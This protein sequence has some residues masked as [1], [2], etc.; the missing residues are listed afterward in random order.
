VIVGKKI[1]VMWGPDLREP[2]FV[3]YLDKVFYLCEEENAVH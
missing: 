2:V 1:G 3:K